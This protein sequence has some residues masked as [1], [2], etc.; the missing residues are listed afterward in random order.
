MN[1]F[2]NI[3]MERRSIRNYKMDE[4]SDEILFKLIRAAQ[5]APSSWN[6]QPWRFIIIKDK[7]KL[8]KISEIL[9]YGKFL[10]RVPMAIAVLSSEKE[11]DLW[12]IDGS[13]AT[14]NLMIAAEAYGLGTCWI[15]D[16]DNVEIKKMLE[17]PEEFHI[18]TIT[19][20][21]YPSR[22]PNPPQRKNMEDILY[23]EKFGKKYL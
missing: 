23:F 22:K 15:A 1:E 18:I 16:A 19:P 8:K 13:L 12:L 3:I 21:G 11:S 17:I 14:E 4:V 20:L 7:E 9:P 2:I 10:S 6:R 5:Y